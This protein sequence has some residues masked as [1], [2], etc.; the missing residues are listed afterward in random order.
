MRNSFV[1][2][3]V[4]LALLV[5]LRHEAGAQ[6]PEISVVSQSYVTIDGRPKFSVNFR[7]G[8]INPNP[9][10]P[11]AAGTY[12]TA[13]TAQNL[14]T[15]PIGFEYRVN[16]GVSNSLGIGPNAV[17]KFDCR[18][19]VPGGSPL[20]SGF[21]PLDPFSEGFFTITLESLFKGFELKVVAVYTVA[22]IPQ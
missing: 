6:G 4:T 19:L 11:L 7:C 12:L 17:K 2:L 14:R 3:A 10:L 5:T 15:Q 16:N 9:G 20:P 18:D 13:I 8:T 1:V 22:T 21:L